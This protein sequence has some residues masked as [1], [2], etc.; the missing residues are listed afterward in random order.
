[1]EEKGSTDTCLL[2]PIGQVIAT[3]AASAS[4][5]FAQR[6][7]AAVERIQEDE[8][9]TS[10]LTDDQARPLIEWACYQAAMAATNAEL[11]DEAVEQAVSAIRRAIFQVASDA[12]NEHDP[13]QLVALA[14]QALEKG[15]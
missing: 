8:R 10:D 7:Q 12:P 15:T 3:S 13:D 4:A 14:Q 9:L 11:S 6:Q 1:M 5:A 2:Y